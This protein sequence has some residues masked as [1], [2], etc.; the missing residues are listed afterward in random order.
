[1]GSINALSP[2]QILFQ[3]GLLSVQ[4]VTS[5][6]RVL[7]IP[8]YGVKQYLMDLKSKI[9]A[10]F[11][12]LLSGL[13][14]SK[15]SLSVRQDLVYTLFDQESQRAC[16]YAMERLAEGQSLGE[17]NFSSNFCKFLEEMMD[18]PNQ[19]KIEFRHQMAH[20][21]KEDQDLGKMPHT[22]ELLPDITIRDIKS[23][24]KAVIEVCRKATKKQ[25][26]EKVEKY[27]QL[28]PKE[29]ATVVIVDYKE[30]FTEIRDFKMYTPSGIKKKKEK[31]AKK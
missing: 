6:E 30:K 31:K 15:L 27:D 12:K 22:E 8:N 25:F 9:P 4:E 28:N 26:Q 16:K 10:G 14:N 13:F 21:K 18:A 3:E 5:K 7:G 20:P 17:W 1:M 2:I 24:K 11:E 29:I 19:Y 23:G